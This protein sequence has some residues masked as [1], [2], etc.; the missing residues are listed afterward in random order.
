MAGRYKVV[1]KVHGHVQTAESWN[2]AKAW[3]KGH[4][5]TFKESL[6]LVTID[7]TNMSDIGQGYF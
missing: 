6:K 2:A 1:C 7:V 3:R 4:A 5:R